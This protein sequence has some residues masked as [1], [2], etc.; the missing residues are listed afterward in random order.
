MMPRAIDDFIQRATR[1]REI[2]GRPHIYDQGR[3]CD[4]VGCITRLS[5]YNARGRCWQHQPATPFVLHPGRNRKG[6]EP[7]PI[8]DSVPW[9]TTSRE[10]R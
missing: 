8:I 3:V 7:R 4:E 5:R 9:E 10:V 6:L 1:V 2:R